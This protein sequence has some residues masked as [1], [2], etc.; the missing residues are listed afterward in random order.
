MARIVLHRSPRSARVVV[1]AISL[2]RSLI[3]TNTL[4]AIGDFAGS[5]ASAPRFVASRAILATKKSQVQQKVAK[6][7]HPCGSG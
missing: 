6:M 4:E 3:R 2:S 5:P 1:I 7:Q